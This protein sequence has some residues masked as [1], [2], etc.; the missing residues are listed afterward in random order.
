MLSMWY[1]VDREKREMVTNA[2]RTAPPSSVRVCT[3]SRLTFLLHPRDRL[4]EC[5]YRYPEYKVKQKD[6]QSDVWLSWVDLTSS[7]ASLK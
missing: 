5:L 6:C 4:G 1:V 2:R 7:P 3:A